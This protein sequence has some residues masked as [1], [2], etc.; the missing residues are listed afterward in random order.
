M[1]EKE[2]PRCPLLTADAVVFVSLSEIVLIRRGRPP[3]Q[4]M[5]ALP[6]GFVDYGETVENAIL[7]EVREETGISGRITGLLGV[8]SE[9][10]RDPRG[11]TVSIA[12]VVTGRREQI[13]PGA[14]AADT[15][16]TGFPP[17]QPLA[18]DHSR[19]IEDARRWLGEHPFDEEDLS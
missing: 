7:R 19:M 13:R 4:N 14:D 16:I 18:F 8:Y 1:P 6:G 10:A 5:W 15:L 11:H 17:S 12:F 2:T 3:F 9:P